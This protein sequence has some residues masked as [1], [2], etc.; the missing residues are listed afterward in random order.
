MPHTKITKHT[1][2][3]AKKFQFP[4]SKFQLRSGTSASIDT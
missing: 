1:K 4:S 3:T 2:K